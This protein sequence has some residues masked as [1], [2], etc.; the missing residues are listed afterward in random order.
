M[1]LRWA[2]SPTEQ[3][4]GEHRLHNNEF[5]STVQ[6]ARLL[7]CGRGW[8]R[9]NANAPC[10]AQQLLYK[11]ILLP[12]RE[13]WRGLSGD[14][15]AVCVAWKTRVYTFAEGEQRGNN[16]WVSTES[17]EEWNYTIHKQRSRAKRETEAL[18]HTCAP[19]LSV[20]RVCFLHFLAEL[21]HKCQGNQLKSSNHQCYKF[22]KFQDTWKA[23]RALLPARIASRLRSGC[24][25]S[26]DGDRVPLKSFLCFSALPLQWH[27]Y[28]M[29]IMQLIPAGH[30]LVIPTLSYRHV[31][32]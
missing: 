21:C 22:Y 29:V 17:K 14:R 20:P 9:D 27:V 23:R 26:R 4:A 11:R 7:I 30:K 32:T 13:R 2:G 19:A 15:R 10:A 12:W 28:V 18:L 1:R 31:H 8:L 24:L 6:P 5:L 16:G 25:A 3:Q